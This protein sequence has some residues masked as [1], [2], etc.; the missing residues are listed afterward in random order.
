M[1]RMRELNNAC[2]LYAANNQGSLPPMMFAADTSSHYIWPSIFPSGGGNPART[3]YLTTYF[4]SAATAQVYVCPSLAEDVPN[5]P[6]IGTGTG[7]YSYSCNE[8]LF[9]LPYNGGYNALPKNSTGQSILRPW[10]LG[11]IRQASLMA[12]FI[13][14][15]ID[16]YTTATEIPGVRTTPGNALDNFW[17]RQDSSAVTTGALPN[18]QMPQPIDQ[19]SFASGN[20]VVPSFVMHPPGSK[21]GSFQNPATGLV[22]PKISANMTVAF[23][24]GSVRTV[25]FSYDGQPPTKNALSGQMYVVPEHPQPRW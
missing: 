12:T 10:K 15:N 13:D 7:Y 8:Y 6:L 17:F 1:A 11:Q 3:C 19:L 25:Y 20:A 4:G 5:T 21:S 2:M 14:A 9:G 16:S 22:T 24:D 23:A 18:Y